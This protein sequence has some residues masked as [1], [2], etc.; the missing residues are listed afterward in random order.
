MKFYVPVLLTL[1]FLTIVISGCGSESEEKICAPGE[2]QSCTCTDGKSGSQAC[3]SSGNDWANCMCESNEI[4]WDQFLIDMSNEICPKMRTCFGTDAIIPNCEQ[5]LKT[6]IEEDGC[7]NF[8][9]IQATP[10]NT[11]LR[12]LTC[13]ELEAIFIDGSEDIGIC[14]VCDLVCENWTD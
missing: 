3:E 12:N 7:R 13:P 8:D 6:L 14:G 4:T 9:P 10:C 11:C 1:I 5:E 2:T